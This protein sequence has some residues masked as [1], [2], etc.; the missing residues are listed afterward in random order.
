LS[1]RLTTV[2]HATPSFERWNN[3]PGKGEMV[4]WANGEM[5]RSFFVRFPFCPTFRS[6][7]L[8][9]EQ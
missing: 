8:F 4:K 7:A 3:T 2:K 1:C 5:E 9:D 6:P